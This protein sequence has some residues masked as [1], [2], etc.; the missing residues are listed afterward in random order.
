MV[1][2]VTLAPPWLLEKIAQIRATPAI[3]EE[4]R[5][6]IDNHSGE[7][8]KC[9][10]KRRSPNGGYLYHFIPR[11]EYD[12]FTPRL[13]L[14]SYNRRAG[15]KTLQI[16][17]AIEL[18]S[19]QLWPLCNEETVLEIP[20]DDAVPNSV[21]LM[22]EKLGN[23]EDDELERELKKAIRD[24][25]ESQR[26]QRQILTEIG[27]RVDIDGR[28]CLH[29]YL[30]DL[31]ALHNGW[32]NVQRIHPEMNLPDLNV[33]SS[34]GIA[35]DRSFI[36]AYRT[37]DAL[38][39]TG[40]EFVHDHL[41]HIITRIDRMMQG[42][43]GYNKEKASIVSIAIDML[44]NT[45]DKAMTI[46]DPT[47]II[48]KE[49]AKIYCII[50]IYTD[51]F[52]SYSIDITKTGALAAIEPTLTNPSR[53]P[54]AWDPYLKKRFGPETT[55]ETIANLWKEVRRLVPLV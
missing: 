54:K 45:I 47:G 48:H 24:E 31:E 20:L 34:A 46:E 18:T 16:F 17:P 1:A 38:L 19:D 22:R 23:L 9:I 3:S 35:D 5:I 14:E 51:F 8:W 43:E 29:L 12:N 37:H 15:Q 6:D 36:N 21:A 42:K 40:K 25:W 50:G 2:S 13:E 27:Y 28:R 4:D 39:S 41:A 7:L 53:A 11:E 44:L 49:E 33:V 52:F 30:P 10:D 32:K 55:F 26:K